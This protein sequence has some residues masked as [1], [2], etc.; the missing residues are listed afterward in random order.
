MGHAVGGER[1]ERGRSEQVYVGPARKQGADD[2]AQWMLVDGCAP[3]RLVDGAPHEE[4]EQKPGCPHDQ[5]RRA[6]AEVLADPAGRHIAEHDADVDAHRVDGER[7]GPPV[8]RKVVGDHGMAR[9]RAGRFADADAH[10]AHEQYR[11][12]SC[13]PRGSGQCAP[14]RDADGEDRAP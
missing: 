13:Q 4:R 1:V 5:E 8:L 6:P 3:G 11:E 12:V 14:H 7:G 10:A 2:F 9:W